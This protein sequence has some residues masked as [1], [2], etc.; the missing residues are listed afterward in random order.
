MTTFPMEAV[1]SFLIIVL[2]DIGIIVLFWTLLSKIE[3]RI[4]ERFETKIHIKTSDL[5]RAITEVI[6]Q[7]RHDIR[8]EC[9]SVRMTIERR[10]KDVENDV[11]ILKT[12]VD[13]HQGMEE[14]SSKGDI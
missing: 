1:L 9:Q 13:R 4:N 14:F 8:N 5:E 7:S 11:K 6:T 12:W 2:G 10:I 3:V